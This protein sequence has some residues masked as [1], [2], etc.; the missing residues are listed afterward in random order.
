MAGNHNDP[1]LAHIGIVD[2]SAQGLLH[3]P[4]SVPA[5]YDDVCSV[6]RGKRKARDGPG[7]DKGIVYGLGY[8]YWVSRDI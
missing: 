8:L 3:F 7:V 6:Y 1:Q 2:A 5:A 4:D